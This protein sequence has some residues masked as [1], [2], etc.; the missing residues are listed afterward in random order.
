MLTKAA[1]LLYD[2][3]RPHDAEPAWEILDDVCGALGDEAGRQ[4]AIGER[5]LMVLARDDFTTAATLFD[6][7]EAI[8]RRIGDRVGLAACVGNR[9]ILLRRTGNLG[10]SLA[11]LDEQR[12]LAKLS[13]NGQGYLFAT[14]NRGE[15]LGAMG[16]VDDGLIA[17]NEARAMAANVGLTQMVEQL[18]QMMAALRPPRR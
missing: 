16:R 4:R 11:C 12:E 1:E 2:A 8:C 15:V 18:D 17:L 5:A 3:G 9:A 6:R 13:G 7:Q 14:A 10:G